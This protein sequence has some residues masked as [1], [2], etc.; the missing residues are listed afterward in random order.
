M[1]ILGNGGKYRTAVI[2]LELVENL[3][4]GSDGP[5]GRYSSS[6]ISDVDQVHYRL[7]PIGRSLRHDE[8]VGVGRADDVA[9]TRKPQH[10]AHDRRAGIGQVKSRNHGSPFPN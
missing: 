1:P 5:V 9:I 7:P 4:G 10:V 3:P 6:R 8:K 2:Q